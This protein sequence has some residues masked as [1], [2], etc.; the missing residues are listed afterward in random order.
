MNTTTDFL[1]R[2]DRRRQLAKRMLRLLAL[3]LLVQ[4]IV[5]PAH[6]PGCLPTAGEP[7]FFTD[8]P[9]GVVAKVRHEE[10][11]TY[12]ELHELREDLEPCCAGGLDLGCARAARG[13][14]PPP[15]PYHRALSWR[16]WTQL[17]LPI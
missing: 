10:E 11:T 7:D 4:P 6:P 2:F 13:A 8:S 5:G 15:A 14:A 3:L 16:A 17:R 9:A 12:E 1:T